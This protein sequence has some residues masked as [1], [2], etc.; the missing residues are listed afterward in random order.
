MVVITES[1]LTQEDL[2]NGLLD[3]LSDHDESKDAEEYERLADAEAP[4]MLSTA[5]PSS[6]VVA[7]LPL[8]ASDKYDRL[9]EIMRKK[10]SKD[11]EKK[12]YEIQKDFQ[13]DMP[14]DE[15]GNTR[16][17]A[18]F[19]FATR[20][21]ALKA[22]QFINMYK[23]DASHTLKAAMVDD[24]DKLV[25]DDN[26]C[27][28]PLNTFGFT[29]ENM[30]SWLF[31][32]D[33]MLDQFVIR[34]ADQTEIHWFDPLERE[35][36]L[37]YNGERERAQGKRVWT[38]QNVEWSRNGTYLV[39]YRRPG[40]ALYGGPTFE[41][42]VRFE[43]RNVQNVLFSPDE[44]Y[45]LTWDGTRG[46]DRHDNSICIWHVI[47]GEKLCAFPTPA[48]SPKGNDF[49]H[50]LWNHNGKY[51]ARLNE[52][53]DG[54][55]I[56]VYKLPEM[57]LISDAEGK[58]APLKYN[59]EKFDWSPTDDI[60]SIVIP[61]TLDT[62]ARLLLVEIPS[63][64]ELSARNVYN[65][66]ASAMHWHPRG[67]CFCLRTTICRKTGKKGR[68]LFNQLEIFRLRE[69]YVP[70]DTI[71]I[72]DATVR[73][74][75]WEEGGSKRFVLVVKDEE[76]STYA[77]R[78][79]RVSDEGTA[80]DTV[81]VA[82]LEL[83]SQM[84]HIL[85]SPAGSYFVTACMGAEGTL[86]FCML[87]DN[88]KVE[89]LYK[90]EHFMM[91][92]L[93]WS[94]CGRYVAS[95]VNVPMPTQCGAPSSD[96]FRYSAE[97]GFCIWTFQGRRLYLSRR[98]NFYSFEFRPTPPPMVDSSV[99]DKIKKNLK[100]YSRK[101]TIMDEKAREE[102]E[103]QYLAKRK[104]AEDAFLIQAAQLMEWLVKQ[105]LYWEFK[106]GWDDF[107][108][109]RYWD[110]TEDVFEEVL[111]VKEEVFGAVDNLLD[112]GH[113]A[114]VLVVYPPDGPGDERDVV[115]HLQ[116]ED[117]H[118][119]YEGPYVEGRAVVELVPVAI[120]PHELRGG[121]LHAVLLH[122]QSPLLQNW[123]V[124]A[125]HDGGV[126]LVHAG[127][128]LRVAIVD[129]DVLA[130]G[131]A[132]AVAVLI[133]A[134]AVRAGEEPVV[135]QPLEDVAGLELRRMLRAMGPPESLQQPAGN[136]TPSKR[137]VKLPTAYAEG[138]GNSGSKNSRNLAMVGVGLRW[139]AKQF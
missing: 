34:Y 95:C 86:L 56:L 122:A 41:L 125:P 19:T 28:P 135:G 84:N 3:W 79:Y 11:F 90:D 129:V 137:P 9:L 71:K 121:D 43:H 96:T 10:L 76:M 119:F 108:N 91:N 78:F 120:Q 138:V 102:Y 63:R 66:S 25:S 49:P 35:P 128:R 7:G 12:G 82:T 116:E 97:A 29:R 61:G 51:I 80:R 103:K 26:K 57:V 17:V 15:D 132:A 83:Q 106:G 81:C 101:Y 74:L 68:K 40:I 67:E 58:P 111:E 6:L 109:E 32:S 93:K 87:N 52:T 118:G 89:V 94:P 92:A 110:I 133:E 38:D 98:D 104:V 31:D 44:E 130:P 42:K 27:T 88:D 105:D 45:L 115:G 53:A 113:Q 23:F 62:P 18:F 107:Y 37:V 112:G 1:H 21:D 33:R 139:A 124:R 127:G 48:I 70:V 20:S 64:R 136:C 59:A 5:F 77:I 55:E 65:V 16:G 8:V 100:E 99:I 114:Q 14:C 134:L 36:V 69:R 30:R 47:T 50:F 117:V 131:E 72:E 73:H 54:N 2:E 4:I 46:A 126:D 75:Y 85:W 60:L 13:I 24:F 39:F 22:Q 123:R